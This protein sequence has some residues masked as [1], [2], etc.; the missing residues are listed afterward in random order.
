MF[1]D[2][3]FRS[4]LPLFYQSAS[5]AGQPQ[6]PLKRLDQFFLFYFSLVNV[7]ASKVQF[8]WEGHKSIGWYIHS[9]IS[10][11]KLAQN[12]PKIGQNKKSSKKK[13][14]AEHSPAKKSTTI[15]KTLKS[16]RFLTVEKFG[17]STS[18]L[19]QPKIVQTLF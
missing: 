11:Q 3:F 1:K 7:K 5:F 9:I 19:S 15:T 16:I 17:E 18:F 6:W 12:W 10:V 4:E 2:F 8:S 14:N 13:S